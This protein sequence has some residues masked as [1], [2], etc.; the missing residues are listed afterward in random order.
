MIEIAFEGAKGTAA[1][2]PTS[3]ACLKRSKY[4]S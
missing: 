2:D 1:K 4:L 3:Q